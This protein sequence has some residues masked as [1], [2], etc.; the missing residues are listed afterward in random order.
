MKWRSPRAVVVAEAGDDSRIAWQV[1]GDMVR[2]D[3]PRFQKE[4][5]DAGEGVGDQS[6]PFNDLTRDGGLER[7]QDGR[8][9]DQFGNERI[10]A[11]ITD[12]ISDAYHGVAAVFS[13][14]LGEVGI[15][16]GLLPPM[17][18]VPMSHTTV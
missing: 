1:I 9:D 2:W 4:A 12:E 18:T 14:A 11:V 7:R 6:N 8:G 17:A 13:V 3:E 5:A 15:V 10:V 16:A